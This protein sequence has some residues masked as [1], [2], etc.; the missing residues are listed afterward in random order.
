MCLESGLRIRIRS[1][2]SDPNPIFKKILNPSIYRTFL[3][4]LTLL[5]MG[6]A[7]CAPPKCFYFFTKNL[8][9]WPNPET[10]LY[11]PN[12]GFTLP[13]IF[14][15]SENLVYKKFYYINSKIFWPKKK[16]FFLWNNRKGDKIMHC[17]DFFFVCF[18]GFFLGIF[19]EFCAKSIYLSP[20]LREKW[21][22]L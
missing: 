10:P 16:I 15:S 11:S 1:F 4:V 2:W 21:L 6:G 5:L 17:V 13:W 20:K 7:L 12:F 22:Y 8:S 9:P 19:N 18:F 14:F 3:T